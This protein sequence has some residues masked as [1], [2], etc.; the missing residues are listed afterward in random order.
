MINP[1][2]FHDL[3]REMYLDNFIAEARPVV[4]EEFGEGT[5]EMLER[6]P[7][8]PYGRG[9][10]WWGRLCSPGHRQDVDLLVRRLE[11]SWKLYP[12]IRRSLRE[13]AEF[14]GTTLRD[15]KLLALQVGLRD[16]YGDAWR[17]R[18]Q[19]MAWLTLRGRRLALG[20][21]VFRGRD[22]VLENRRG[23]LVR[24]VDF[25]PC[26]RVRWYARSARQAADA[27]VRGEPWPHNPTDPFSPQ[28]KKAARPRLVSF[29]ELGD[30]TASPSP[31]DPALEQVDLTAGLQSILP[32]LD[33][34]TRGA[35]LDLVGDGEGLQ[36]AIVEALLAK[37]DLPP[38]LQ[39]MADAYRESRTG[40][41]PEVYDILQHRYPDLKRSTLRKR[42]ERLLDAIKA[43]LPHP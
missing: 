31:E 35:I 40:D 28:P 42:K 43:S 19:R 10:D 25:P 18:P 29:D 22:L 2:L 6:D 13:R 27:Y 30:A 4:E 21:N 15:Q 38:V 7:D 32:A 24:P 34:A 11:R 23:A 17:P 39:E 8:D 3:A 16:A 37:A 1:S 12:D 9:D 26:N 14:D 36:Y 33:V 41:W 20:H 5:V